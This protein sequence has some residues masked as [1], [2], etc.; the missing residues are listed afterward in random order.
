MVMF[1]K[2]WRC[3]LKKSQRNDIMSGIWLKKPLGKKVEE[4]DEQ[5]WQNDNHY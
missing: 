5:E 3:I 2:S 4:M 1:F